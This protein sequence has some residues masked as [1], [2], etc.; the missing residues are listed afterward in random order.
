MM[1]M[2]SGIYAIFALLAF[3]LIY[4]RIE[5]IRHDKN[6]RSIAIRIWVNGSRGKSSVT[7][8]I[9]AGMRVKGKKVIA[10][11]TGT[12]PRYI[13]GNTTEEEV[14][15]L[16]MPNIREQ[17]RVFDKA[18]KETPDA[19]VLECMALRPDLQQ[20]EAKQL[21]SPNAVVITNIRPDHLDVMGPSLREV[22]QTYL[23][24][25]PDECDIFI[26]DDKNYQECIHIIKRKRLSLHTVLPSS[27]TDRDMEGFNYT[28]HRENVALALAVCQHFGVDRQ[29]ALAGMQAAQADPGALRT[30]HL[31]FD[32]KSVQLVYAMAANDPESTYR[33]WD[34]LPKEYQQINILVNCRDDRID[35][36]FQIKK[37]LR[38]H[39]HDADN[40]FLTGTGTHVLRRELPRFIN[41]DKIF[42]FGDIDAVHAVK[43]ILKHVSHNSLIFAMGNTVGYG[44]ELIE[45]FI[46]LG[47]HDAD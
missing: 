6:R 3:F 8:L 19:I 43:R 22:T 45:S 33:I 5:K 15:R 23:H 18:K 16:G 17:V 25:V 28:E 41:S 27:I 24:A 34:T 47:S 7:R 42:L 38:E 20:I 2:P 12:A 21:I 1:V 29:N 9:A 37:L 39:L 30:Y 11:T 46:K 4:Y 44:M 10:K 40:Y 32:G 36:S 31:R 26:E 14:V 35:R 13:T